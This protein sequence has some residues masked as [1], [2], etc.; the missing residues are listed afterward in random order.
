MLSEKK[1]KPIYLS[2]PE[3]LPTAATTLFVPWGTP[4]SWARKSLMNCPR[5][6][7]LK[8]AFV[9]NVFVVPVIT[10]CAPVVTVPNTGTW[11]VTLF[12]IWTPC[13][14][15]LPADA[16][17]WLTPF[18]AEVNRP[19]VASD[20]LPSAFRPSSVAVTTSDPKPVIGSGT[21][22][23]TA[24]V[25]VLKSM[26]VFDGWPFDA[27]EVVLALMVDSSSVAAGAAGASAS[28]NPW[29]S[30]KCIASS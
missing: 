20:S 11:P 30:C 28:G 19:S 6:T 10:F 21:T 5:R 24:D 9:L 8:L 16:V 7:L 22:D 3:V 25:A 2:S 26:G 15:T 29:L 12:T 14:T 1:K 4:F 18:I 27:T 17:V 13:A 23:I